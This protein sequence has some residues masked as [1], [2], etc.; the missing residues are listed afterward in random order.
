M[1]KRWAALLVCVGLAL[2]A[3][4][5]AGPAFRA[6][7]T[8]HGRLEPVGQV[9]LL[10]LDGSPAERGRAAGQLV[11]EQVRWLLPRY[12]RAA[13]GHASLPP[14]ASQRLEELSAFIP[15]THRLQLAAL[16]AAA[17][18]EP[19]SLLAVNLATEL[20]AGPACSCLA[21]SHE[22][23]PDARVRLARNLDWLGGELLAGMGLVVLESGPGMRTFASFTWPGLVGAVS[24]MNDAGV[25]VADLMAY[26][27]GRRKLASGQPV[28]FIVRSLLERSGSVA[29]ALGLLEGYRRTMPQNYAL[30]D[31]GGAAM[32]ETSPERFRLRSQREGLHGITNF[33]DEDRAA[34]SG[35]RYERMFHSVRQGKQGPGELRAVLRAVALGRQNVQALVFEPDR[36]RVWISVGGP[37]AAGGP[38][39]ELDL[40]ERLA[41]SAAEATGDQSP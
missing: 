9:W 27:G 33:W 13:I 4:A 17:G 5:Q 38:W 24:G 22:R 31:A 30:A 34:Q 8:D 29:Q 40:A 12:L 16:A 15:E 19:E 6:A 1:I 11:G 26:P 41:G 36:R 20:S 10:T 2:S 37:P 35:G 28:L 3:C 23:S 14:S 21:T 32:V 18:V 39:V 25:C 7:K